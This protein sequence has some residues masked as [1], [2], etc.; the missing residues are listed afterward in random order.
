MAYFPP[1]L[2]VHE[3][4]ACGTIAKFIDFMLSKDGQKVVNEVKYVSMK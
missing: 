2:H 4:K 1:A 3:W